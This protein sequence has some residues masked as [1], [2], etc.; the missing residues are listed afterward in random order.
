[1]QIRF[2]LLIVFSI[3]ISSNVNAQGRSNH[4]QN[5]PKGT[6]LTIKDNINVPAYNSVVEIGNPKNYFKD[7]FKNLSLVLHL[8]SEERLINKGTAFTIN[9][10]EYIDSRDSKEGT[11]KIKMYYGDKREFFLCYMYP[12]QA[13][14]IEVLQ[15]YF[16]V[17]LP[18]AR[19][20]ESN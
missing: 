17:D 16:K 12:E 8:S 6:V 14:K 15:Q 11:Y 4:L 10:V 5:L 9:S 7:S 18:R 1:M 2:F 20:Y 19:D 13:P 3:K